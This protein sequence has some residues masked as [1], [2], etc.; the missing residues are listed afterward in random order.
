MFMVCLPGK[1]NVLS[2]LVLPTSVMG[3]SQKSGLINRVDAT[4]SVV[5]I[6]FRGHL[7]LRALVAGW[8]RCHASAG[9][10]E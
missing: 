3:F 2:Q 6:G 5:G 9:C 4:D 10:S 1:K 8:C 7:Y